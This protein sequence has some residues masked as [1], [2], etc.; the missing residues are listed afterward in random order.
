MKIFEENGKVRLQLMDLKKNV[1]LFDFAVEINSY[2]ELRK[3]MIDHLTDNVII[4]G[5]LV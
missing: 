5:E 1:M 2:N 4:D 3:H